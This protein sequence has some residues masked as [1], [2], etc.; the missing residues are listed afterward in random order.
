MRGWF[1]ESARV[2]DI[3][4]LRLGA[5]ASPELVVVC[6]CTRERPQALA[7]CLPLVLS[8]QVPSSYR[9]HVV[10][11]D[12]SLSGNERNNVQEL[13]GGN[14]HYVH[15]PVAG[16]P[17]ARNAAISEA[18]RLDSCWIV[19][20]DDDCVPTSG[21]LSRLLEIAVATDADV[22]QG[23]LMRN[24]GDVKA[25]AAALSRS[26][27]PLAARRCRN[28][29]TNNV[30]LRSW[31]VAE[32][33]GLRFDIQ[34]RES[35]GS[36]GEFFMRAGDIGAIIMRTNDAP[37]LEAWGE[38]RSSPS[39]S[40]MR[41]FR[42]GANCNYRYRKNRRPGIWAATLILVRAGERFGRWGLRM[43]YS[44]L[45]TPFSF[46]RARHVA[47]MGILD[48]CFAW[49]CIAPYFGVRTTKYY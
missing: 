47:W 25:D 13:T 10:V 38:E 9:L 3:K 37:V 4:R 16:I 20:I 35:G 40:C 12:N 32:P 6:V 45:L 8:Q 14:V 29:A 34:M 22:L 46:R 31:I 5:A 49:G 30:L 1:G 33:V 11:V 17:I 21:W 18:L 27:R 44:T 41:A 28:A 36:D 2:A 15:E 39:Y 23:G 24:S 48:L 7:R 19:F 26:P 42:V 43:L